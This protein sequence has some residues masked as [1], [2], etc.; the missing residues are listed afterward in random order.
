MRKLGGQT[1]IFDE[2]Q[3]QAS[4]R[5]DPH[6]DSVVFVIFVAKT[7]FSLLTISSSLVTISFFVL[8]FLFSFSL[9]TFTSSSSLSIS[10]SAS[11]SCLKIIQTINPLLS[12]SLPFSCFYTLVKMEMMMITNKKK[13]MTLKTR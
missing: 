10:S 13:T 3:C 1:S 11:V 9:F 5:Q 4:D 6:S 8:S 2:K 12:S 7:L